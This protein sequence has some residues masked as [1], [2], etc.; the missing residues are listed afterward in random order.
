MF[1]LIPPPVRTIFWRLML[2]SIWLTL[3]AFCGWTASEIVGEGAGP[4][5]VFSLGAAGMPGPVKFIIRTHEN[6]PPGRGGGS[7][8]SRSS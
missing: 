3:M 6:H 4:A 1:S 2:L 8:K 7:V 5:S